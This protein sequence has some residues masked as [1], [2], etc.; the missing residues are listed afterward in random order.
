M[1]LRVGTLDYIDKSTLHQTLAMFYLKYTIGTFRF[2]FIR[3]IH[4]FG[5]AR[6]VCLLLISHQR[7]PIR[8]VL[9]WNNNTNMSSVRLLIHHARKSGY[10]SW[11][12]WS[13]Q[14]RL[15]NV[16]TKEKSVEKKE[17]R[18]C[19]A[20]NSTD[21]VH[22]NDHTK[23]NSGILAERRSKIFHWIQWISSTFS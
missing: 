22:L 10:V 14:Y 16:A 23:M 8:I 21:T 2:H 6:C 9:G 20:H 13:Q 3:I 17:I 7:L 1:E 4:Q 19:V 5:F 12:Q 15:K 11:N 18:W